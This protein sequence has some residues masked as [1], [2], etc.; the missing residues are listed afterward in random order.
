VIPAV[1]NDNESQAKPMTQLK[2][3]VSLVLGPV[4][5]VQVLVILQVRVGWHVHSLRTPV[6]SPTTHWSIVNYK[7]PRDLKPL[8]TTVLPR[9]TWPVQQI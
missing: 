4:L 5:I 3:S 1:V 9:G 6:A 7:P 2:Q 8:P